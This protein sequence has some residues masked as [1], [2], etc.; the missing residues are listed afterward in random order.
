MQQQRNSLSDLVAQGL[1]CVGYVKHSSQFALSLS[2]EAGLRVPFLFKAAFVSNFI[3]W[4]GRPGIR[5][6]VFIIELYLLLTTLTRLACTYL[7]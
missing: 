2:V 3:I 5:E 6:D 4:R 7:C 1:Y